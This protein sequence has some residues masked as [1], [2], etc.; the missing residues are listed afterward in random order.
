M[1]VITLPRVPTRY[2][3]QH[4]GCDSISGAGILYGLVGCTGR[5]GFA[6]GYCGTTIARVG[7]DYL[8]AAV[9]DSSTKYPRTIVEAGIYNGIEHPAL[10]CDSA[11]GCSNICHRL[12]TEARSGGLPQPAACALCERTSLSKPAYPPRRVPLT[13]RLFYAQPFVQAILVLPSSTRSP[14][15]AM[16]Y[17]A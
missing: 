16:T 14:P 1:T 11:L 6:S 15:W 5:M 12:S 3:W 10:R 8:H 2:D 9:E 13:R 17:A 7:D 4:T